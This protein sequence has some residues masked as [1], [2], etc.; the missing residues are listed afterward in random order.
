MEQESVIRTYRASDG[1]TLHYRHDRPEVTPRGYIVAVHG[2]QSHSGWYEYSSKRMCEAGFDVRFLDRRGS[3]LNTELRGYAP[4]AD[5]L[6]NDVVQALTQVQHEREATGANV[7]ITLMS[8][9]WGGKLAAATYV[10]RP[11]LID[12]LALLY[13]GIHSLKQASWTERL[14]L[15]VARRMGWQWTQVDIP[16]REPALFTGE[17]HWQEFIRN[18]DLSLQQVALGF[19]HADRRLAQLAQSAAA[20]IDCPLLMMLAGQDEIIDNRRLQTF[21]GAVPHE[22]KRLIMYDNARHTLEFEPDRER[23][24][25]D[26][27]AWLD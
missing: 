21:F 12:R 13:P 6:I 20:N 9:S 17:P 24:V 14:K 11:E 18:D 27:I 19:L 8:V 10:S 7:P 3:G 26:L 22:S 23:I 15:M 2:I 16:L 4:H 1:Y 25:D 5:R